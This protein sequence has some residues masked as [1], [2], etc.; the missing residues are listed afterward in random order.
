ML[1]GTDYLGSARFEP[2]P[3]AIPAQGFMLVNIGGEISGRVVIIRIS[4]SGLGLSDQIL[5]FPCIFYNFLA[6]YY[7]YI[8]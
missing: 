7:K 5:R 4:E 3:N 1:T 2:D 8:F 6:F